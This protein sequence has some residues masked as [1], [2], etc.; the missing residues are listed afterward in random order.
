MSRGTQVKRFENKVAVVTGGVSGI[1]AAVTR[2]LLDEGASV[3]VADISADVATSATETFGP[4]V[5]GVRTDV[6]DPT[7]VTALFAEAV[8]R[9]ETIDAVFNVAGGQKPGLIADLDF[10]TWKFNIALNLHGTF[11]GVQAA[12]RTFGELGKTGSITNMASLN[13]FT[14]MFGGAAYA[15]A[16]AGVAM[17]TKNAALEFGE[18]GIRVNAIS[19]G[20][21]ATPLTADLFKIPGYE[22]TALSRIPAGRPARPEEIAGVAAFLASEDAAYISGEN[23]VVD[24]AWQTTGYPDLRR[25]FS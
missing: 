14:P 10:E 5:A 16:K 20:L 13:S 17:L 4:S 9:F 11:L 18:V 2:R 25:F 22:E 6:T 19:P 12:A 8:E 7:S 1:G 24:G 21:V 23:L 3:V 15:T